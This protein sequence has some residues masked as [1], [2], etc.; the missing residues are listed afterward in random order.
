MA[1][2]NRVC[3]YDWAIERRERIARTCQVPWRLR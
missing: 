3:R 2:R 1:G